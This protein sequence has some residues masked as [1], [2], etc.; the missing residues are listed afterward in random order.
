VDG[1]S[2]S[3]LMATLRALSKRLVMGVTEAEAAT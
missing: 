1:R 2:K 3:A